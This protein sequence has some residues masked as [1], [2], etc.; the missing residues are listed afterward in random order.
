MLYPLAGVAPP[1]VRRDVAS[2]LE[3]LKKE[4]DPRH[5]LHHH[6]LVTQRLKNRQSFIKEV[7]P[8]DGEAN[9]ARLSLWKERYPTT[10]LIPLS[11]HLPPGHDL[12]WQ[13]WKSLIRL[14]TQVGRS[15]ENMH[16]WGYSSESA[17]LCGVS[18]Q[19]MAHLLSCPACPY[20]CTREGL[21][22][23]TDNALLVT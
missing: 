19:T 2:S 7:S 3:R 4:T 17:C 8:L 21:Y 9:Q 5:P 16:R 15:K 18:P 13:T 11:E 20:T 6:V 10:S 14:R 12:P 22:N 23:A 1:D